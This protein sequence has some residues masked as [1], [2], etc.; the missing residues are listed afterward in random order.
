[1]FTVLLLSYRFRAEQ[2]KTAHFFLIRAAGYAGILAGGIVLWLFIAK[3]PRLVFEMMALPLPQIGGAHDQI[4]WFASSTGFFSH[5]GLLFKGMA[6]HYL[7]SALFYESLRYFLLAALVAFVLAIVW[8]VRTRAWMPLFLATGLIGSNFALALIQG[9]PTPYRACQS[10]A[11]MVGVVWMSL[12]LL[13]AQRV[14]LQRIVLVVAVLLVLFQSRDLSLW[15]YNNYRRFEM[16]KNNFQTMV[17]TLESKFGRNIR[18]PV[19]VVGEVPAYPTLRNDDHPLAFLPKKYGPSQENGRN[20]FSSVGVRREFYLFAKHVCGFVCT[21]PTTEQVVEAQATVRTNQQPAWPLDGYIR[22][23]DQ[24][25]VLNLGVDESGTAQPN[26]AMND[27]YLSDNEKE[28]FRKL[29][30]S[31]WETWMHEHMEGIYR[32]LSEGYLPEVN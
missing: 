10:F 32:A 16:D 12:Y 23:Y 25:V 26:R 27:T 21:L 31:E 3:A 4:A 20:R 11:V 19:V 15:F 22:E 24:Y 17:N 5:M 30:V 18:K 2:P 8:S 13:A 29:R 14:R 7:Y 6:Y 1:M 28:L 9:A